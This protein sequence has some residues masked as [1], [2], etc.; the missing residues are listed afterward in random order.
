M[1]GQDV[2]LLELSKER[3]PSAFREAQELLGSNRDEARRRLK[4]LASS[5]SAASA[6]SLATSDRPE[7]PSKLYLDE[8]SEFWLK[9][10]ARLG[11]N[12]AAYRLGWLYMRA[13]RHSEAMKMFQA[14]VSNKYVPAF[15]M[16]ALFYEYGIGVQPDT[17]TARVLLEEGSEL[18]GLRARTQLAWLLIRRHFG[19]R[20]KLRGFLLLIS[21]LVVGIWVWR[22]HGLY[23]VRFV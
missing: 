12:L 3:R 17:T 8:T 7:A 23:S 5:G 20:Q 13:K 18:G 14:G 21:A 15:R 10:A 6:Y 4:E 16:L 11:C 2:V 22:R 19:L 9:E 1:E